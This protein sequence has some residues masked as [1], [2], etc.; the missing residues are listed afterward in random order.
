MLCISLVIY[1]LQNDARY[2][3]CQTKK[4]VFQYL[5]TLT[6]MTFTGEYSLVPLCR[7]CFVNLIRIRYSTILITCFHLFTYISTDFLVVAPI[8]QA[9]CTFCY[10]NRV[11]C[12][13]VQDTEHAMSA[14]CTVHLEA[15]R[16]PHVFSEEWRHGL[17]FN[18]AIMEVC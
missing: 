8:L 9:K 11:L 6:W 13:Q 4:I 14:Y 3:Q 5:Y 15:A 7:C 2:I 12:L 1:I 18:R 16:C 10:R 17:F